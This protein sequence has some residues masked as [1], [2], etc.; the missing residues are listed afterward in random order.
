MSNIWQMACLKKILVILLGVTLSGCVTYHKYPEHQLENKPEQ[1][2][3]GASFSMKGGSIAGGS[4]R[5]KKL[6]K[7]SSPFRNIEEIDEKEGKDEP[8]IYIKVKVK[9]AAPSIPAL[10]FG[11]LSLSTLTLLPVWSTQDGNDIIFTVYKDGKRIK[12]FEYE[13]RRKAAAWIV[14]LPIVWV[15]FLTRSEEEAF[16]AVTNQFFEDLV[17]VI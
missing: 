4:K 8:G 13:V 2:Y 10:G 6:M 15:N 3:D 17:K 1:A 11:Y 9:T 12:R 14:M 5:I 7:T 16:T